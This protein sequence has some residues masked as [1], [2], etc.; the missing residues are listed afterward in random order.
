M[1]S[2]DLL[3]D[4]GNE[5]NALDHVIA[6]VIYLHRKNEDGTF[7][8]ES[9]YAAASAIQNLYGGIENIFKR[10]HRYYGLALPYGEAS[11]QELLERFTQM[12]GLPIGS[13]SLP[14]L[15]SPAL[16]PK[17]FLLKKL[18][19]VVA[20]GYS[21]TLQQE[22]LAQALAEIPAIYEIFKNEVEQYCKT[23]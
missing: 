5:L 7:D 20:H 10:L 22:S 12:Q 21:H 19:H 14:V 3:K 4:I 16:F 8:E 9:R 11:H 2:A 23:L 18:R 1:T 15:I 13:S 6:M 17:M